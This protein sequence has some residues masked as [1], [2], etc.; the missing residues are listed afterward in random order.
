MFYSILMKTFTLGM[1]H[2]RTY[3]EIQSLFCKMYNLFDLQSSELMDILAVKLD[4]NQTHAWTK[5]T[6][7]G[8]P[9]M[10]L[11]IAITCSLFISDI[12]SLI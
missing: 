10:R 4:L 5:F 3:F 1:Q 12:Q 7:T 8:V 9:W 6:Y 11:H 2:C